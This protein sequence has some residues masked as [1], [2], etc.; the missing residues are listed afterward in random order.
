MLLCKLTTIKVIWV[1]RWT[2]ANLEAENKDLGFY[3][4]VYFVFVSLAILGPL[5]ECWVFF[6]HIVK[7]TAIKLHS[8]L[9]QAV[10][11]A[12]FHFFLRTD[13]GTIAN[14]FS[15]DM[16][17]IDMTL[18]SQALQFTSGLAWCLVQLIVLCV[19]GKTLSAVVPVLVLVLFAIQ[20]YYLRTS[21]QLRM[22]DIEAKAPLYAHFIDTIR[23]IETIRAFGWCS[24]FSET[25]ATALDLSQRPFYMLFCVQQWLTLVLDLVSGGLAVTLVAL[26]LSLSGGSGLGMSP[27]A[28]GVAL[29]L[30]LQ[31]NGLLN[32]TIQAWTKIETSIGAVARVRRFVHDTP[33]E[34]TGAAPPS[35]TWPAAGILALHNLTAAHT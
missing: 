3:L 14:H 15:Q 34:P 25:L 12:P 2:A 19:L 31:F 17:L 6:L 13:I 28:L 8:D 1:D 32:Q 9:V 24:S 33:A 10:V 23:G 26:A 30:T 27:G 35:D 5:G 7:D 11:K 21:R 22:L 4:G 16:N 18:P 29:V 20:R